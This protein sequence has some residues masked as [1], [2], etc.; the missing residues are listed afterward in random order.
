MSDPCPNWPLNHCRC[1][2]ITECRALFEVTDLNFAATSARGVIMRCEACGALYPQ[3]FPDAATL[4]SAYRDYYTAPR[5]RGGWRAWASAVADLTRRDYMRRGLPRGARSVLDFGCGAGAFLQHVAATDPALHA[6]G[7][8]VGAQPAAG[9]FQWL[10][11]AEIETAGPYDWITLGHVVEHLDDPARRLASLAGTLGPGGG[12]WIATPNA[13]SFL[14]ATA[15][16]WARDLDFP[17]HREIFSRAGLERLLDEAGLATT[18]ASP[19]RINAALNA[20]STLRNILADATAPTSA[21]LRA[22][23]ATLSGLAYHCLQTPAARR[24]ASPELVVVC[25]KL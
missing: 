15:G 23:V 11:P 2:P 19:P 17:R 14:F 25:R 3:R 24:A 21:R 8:D 5:R 13:D 7:S 22:V 4:A 18:F 16:R 1:R 10:R 20:L 6:Y 12:I 9:G